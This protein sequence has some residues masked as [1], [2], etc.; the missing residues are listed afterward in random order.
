MSNAESVAAVSGAQLV[1]RIGHWFTRHVVIPVGVPLVLSAWAIH[2]YL[3]ESFDYSP[4]IALVS[5][6]KRCGKNGH[7]QCGGP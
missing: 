6:V 5:P 7:E 1:A 4:Y 2:T 3:Y